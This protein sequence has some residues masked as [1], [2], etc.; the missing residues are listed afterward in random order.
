MNKLLILICVG[1]F[2]SCTVASRQAQQ[3]YEN[4][5]IA[6]KR[7]NEQEAILLLNTAVN[8]A[9]QYYEAHLKLGEFYYK[10]KA[11]PEAI[12]SL[13]QAN[14]L[15]SHKHVGYVLQGKAYIALQQYPEAVDVLNKAISLD[16]Q[17]AESRIL[18]GK[19]YL[20]QKKYLEAQYQYSQT[21]KFPKL[22]KAQS[23]QAYLGKGIC[24]LELKLTQDAEKYLAEALSLQPKDPDAI[25]YNGY[26]SE[27]Q[28]GGPNLQ[29]RKAYERVLSIVPHHLQ[30]LRHLGRMW[31]ELGRNS[32]AARLYEKFLSKGG[33]SK[34]VEDFM[35]QSPATGGDED[36]LMV[37]PECG[38][39]GRVG[40]EICDYDGAL[41]ESQIEPNTV[42]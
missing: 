37:C 26:L 16:G 15:N 36:S 41:L 42:D 34:H 33:Q 6:W 38:R 24:K 22:K 28:M 39:F 32:K 5:L 3:N 27:L 1:L 19:A 13:E 10:T 31:Q 23:F 4:G 9:P 14:R 7:G 35:K 29:S 30:S 18:L 25:F 8:S 20:K 12:S 40:E 21:L 17:H 2:V 11:Y